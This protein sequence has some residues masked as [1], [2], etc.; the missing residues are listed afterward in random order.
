MISSLELC[1]ESALAG[2]RAAL[3]CAHSAAQ[4]KLGSDVEHH[5]IVSE[6]DYLSQEAIL[7]TLDQ[8]D[9]QA[10]FITE[11]N[12]KDKRLLQKILGPERLEML[13]SSRVYIIDELDGS[14]SHNAGHYEWSI[15]VGCV[16]NGIPVAGAVY[17]PSVLGGF[18][19]YGSKGEGVF[20]RVRGR[21]EKVNASE[22][23][24]E[25]SYVYFGVDCV[26][27]DKYP[28]HHQLMGT[29]S[30]LVR[31]TNMNGSCALPLALI[32]AGRGEALVQPIQSV[33]DYAAGML[34]VEEAGG[35]MLFY[36]MDKQGACFSID[37]LELR[38]YN[39]SKR[40]VGFIAGNKM[41]VEHITQRYLI[42]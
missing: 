26:L 23:S 21:D 15:S 16:E 19:C 27:S 32:A 10:L 2:G 31:T 12:V 6:A 17:A 4:K 40:N 22:K 41:I 3:H 38:H 14:S 24:L 42:K 18:L 9:P 20:E 13:R 5:A 8:K 30:P 1:I 28:L 36:E 11:E 34:L 37:R 7:Y 29:L 39:P 33:W 35:R 25:D